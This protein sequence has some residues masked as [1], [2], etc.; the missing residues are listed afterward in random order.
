MDGFVEVL[1]PPLIYAG[2]W[3]SERLGKVH[4]PE[5]VGQRLTV[6]QADIDQP[7]EF[8]ISFVRRI[9]A[10]HSALSVLKSF[11]DSS[12]RLNLSFGSSVG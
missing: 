8:F 11:S 12:S 3:L 2:R 9:I 6:L 10:E 4:A 5:F 7:G 1:R